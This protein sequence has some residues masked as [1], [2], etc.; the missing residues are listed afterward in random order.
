MAH[1]ETGALPYKQL[2]HKHQDARTRLL[3]ERDDGGTD[4]SATLETGKGTQAA[5][6]SHGVFAVLY[7]PHQTPPLHHLDPGAMESQGSP[8]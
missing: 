2:Q 6:P 7:S 1:A 3:A 4:H 8:G 5:L